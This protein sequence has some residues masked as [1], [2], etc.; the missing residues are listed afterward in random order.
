MGWM[1][2]HPEIEPD[3]S[4]RAVPGTTI[5][6]VHLSVLGG[7]ADRGYLGLSEDAVHMSFAAIRAHYVVVQFFNCLCADC[8]RELTQM[9]ALRE[10]LE[11]KDLS[12]DNGVPLLRFIGI[13]VHD[14]ARRVAAFRKKQKTGFPLFVDRSGTLLEGLGITAPPAACLLE[15]TEQ[16]VIVR[17]LAAGS[18]REREAFVQMVRGLTE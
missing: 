12:G 1:A 14:E 3:E 10:E 9:D 7:H 8:L 2:S 18:D 15:R 6:D 16:G 17:A 13:A 5:T 4:G 11:L